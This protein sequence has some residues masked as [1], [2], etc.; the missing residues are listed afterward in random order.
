MAGLLFG[1][2]L[3]ILLIACANLVNLFLSRMAAREQEI[4]TRLALGASGWRIVRQLLTES[5]S[6]A[7][8]GAAGGLA[9]AVV[10]V[11]RLHEWLF[12]MVTS[13]GY[14]VLPLELDWGVVAYSAGLGLVAAAA[15]GLFPAL[16]AATVVRRR[17]GSFSE[18]RE[19]ETG[20]TLQFGGTR[21]RAGA[22][23]GLRRTR[24]AR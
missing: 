21:T 13:H 14:V 16:N 18:V 11:A 2:V 9:L 7:L 6:L 17:P 15:F 12:S 1:S 24:A 19:S 5:T 8:L 3:L 20:V 10:S 22:R 23:G 4:A